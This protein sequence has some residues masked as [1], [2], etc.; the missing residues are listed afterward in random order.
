MT[1]LHLIAAAGLAAI[2]APLAAQT[3]QV[4]NPAPTKELAQDRGYDKQTPKHDAVDAQEAPVTKALNGQVGVATSDAMVQNATNQ[5]T[6]AADM[7]KYRARVEANAHATMADQ[8]R[9]ARQQH[10]YADAMAAWRVQ[11]E[12][13][14]KGSKAA[15]NAPVPDPASFY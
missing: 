1:R 6:Y 3:A 2:A 14:Q 12:A 5:E 7:A 10:A 15:C 11:T 13:C 4:P 8:D 9:Y